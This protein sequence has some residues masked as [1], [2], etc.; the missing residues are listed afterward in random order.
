MDFSTVVN[1]FRSINIEQVRLDN[2]L[3]ELWSVQQISD[4]D[5]DWQPDILYLGKM[6]QFSR[7]LSTARGA[8][9]LLL[10]KDSTFPDSLLCRTDLNLA[11]LP[12]TTELKEIFMRLQSV[13]LDSSRI[14][15]GMGVLLD[16]LLEDKGLQQLAEAAVRVFRMS[17]LIS[18]KSYKILA[19]ASNGKDTSTIVEL[20]TRSGYIADTLVQEIQN[21][22]I[23]DLIR[24]AGKPTLIVSSRGIEYLVASVVVHDVEVAH[25]SLITGGLPVGAVEKELLRRFSQIIANELQKNNFF[26]VNRGSLHASF[27][28]DLFEN[29]INSLIDARKRLSIFGFSL[30]K[31]QQTLSISIRDHIAPDLK[32]QTVLGQ[33]RKLIPDSIHMIYQGELVFLISRSSAAGLSSDEEAALAAFLAGQKLNAGLSN[34]FTDILD[35]RRHFS[36]ARKAAELG[37]KYDGGKVLHKY[38]ELIVSHIA[39]LCESRVNLLDL[40]HPALLQLR[41]LD[42]QH[43]TTLYPT[44]QTYLRLARNPAKTSAELTV[45]RNTLF[46]RVR[47][48]RQLTGIDIEDGDELMQLALSFKLLDILDRAKVKSG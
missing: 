38:D 2:P 30:K 18:D 10:L 5:I 39:E 22:R 47:K 3:G 26:I 1:S 28:A 13:F 48:I 27:L 15:S 25:V 29:K 8:V 12:E 43:G 17:V 36:Q 42:R 23:D 35:T 4:L 19:W 11:L 6:S 7:P 40:C 33:L 20:D 24:K 32:L 34:R 45:H 14:I 41:L 21:R 46:Y 16:A 9:S 37:Q 31:C 44:L